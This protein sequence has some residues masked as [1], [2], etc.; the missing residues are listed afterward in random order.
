MHKSEFPNWKDLL[1]STVAGFIALRR[2]RWEYITVYIQVGALATRTRINGRLLPLRGPLEIGHLVMTGWWGRKWCWCIA[3]PG[4]HQW[5]RRGIL[6]D[7]MQCQLRWG[8][9]AGAVTAGA[10]GMSVSGRDRGG[11]IVGLLQCPRHFGGGCWF[12]PSIARLVCC[13][14]HL[15]HILSSGKAEG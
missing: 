14:W 10:G 13:T 2:W 12:I 6:T 5:S 4:C 3:G 9:A 1:S 7:R 11:G 8:D 15:R